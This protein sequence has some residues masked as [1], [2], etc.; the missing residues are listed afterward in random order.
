MFC[1]KHMVG[2][3]SSETLQDYVA[4]NFTTNNAAVVGLGVDHQQLVKYAENMCLESGG[5]CAPAA[6]KFHSG[7]IR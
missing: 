7:E 3:I 4:H 6:S 1:P 5:S 2:K